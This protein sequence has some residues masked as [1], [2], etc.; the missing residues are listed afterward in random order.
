[1]TSD[2]RFGATGTCAVLHADEVVGLMLR[3]RCE[4]IRP[5]RKQRR[6]AV[7]RWLLHPFIGQVSSPCRHRTDGTMCEECAWRWA[8]R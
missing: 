8:I 5:R 4:A 2:M 7:L 3:L 6:S 1:M